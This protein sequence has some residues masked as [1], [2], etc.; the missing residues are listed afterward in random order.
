VETFHGHDAIN[1][2]PKNI[3]VLGVKNTLT[4]FEKQS[5]RR[6]WS[7]R[8]KSG[9]SGDF[10]TVLADETCVYAHTGGELFCVDLFNGTQRW[11]DAL[12]GLG[13]GI[14]SLAIPGLGATNLASLAE[15]QRHDAA[16][17]A[18]THTSAH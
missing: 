17:A 16:A 13:Y 8:L 14:A 7:T 12:P 10:V 2:D 9:M 15:R 4:A 6:L 1:M 11:A 5:G 18:T 3:L